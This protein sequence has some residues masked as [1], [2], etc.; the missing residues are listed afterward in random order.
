MKNFVNTLAWCMKSVVTAPIFWVGVFIALWSRFILFNWVGSILFSLF[1]LC[2]WKA[3]AIL[4][5]FAAFGAI[6]SIGN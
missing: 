3:R 1:V 4:A 6:S 5:I 2:C